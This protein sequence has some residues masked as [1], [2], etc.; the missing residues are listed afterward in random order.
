MTP[1]PFTIAVADDLIADLHRRL[2]ATLWPQA[3][4]GSGWDY[5]SDLGYVQEV[6]EHWRHRYDWRVHERR[7][8]RL[9]QYLVALDG[10][11]VHCVHVPG[12]GPAPLPLVITHGWPSSFAEM[13]D[14]V[15]PLT[16][17]GGHGGDHADAFHVVV[18]SL[19]GY[20]FSSPPT[21]RGMGA[22]RV[23]D[24]WVRLMAAFGYERF[25]SQG[26]DWG[27]AVTTALAVRHPERLVGIHLSMVAPP[28]DPAKLTAEQQIWADALAAYR[29]AE[30]GYVHLQRTKPQ[31]PA[32]ALTDSPA[33]LAAWLVEKWWRWTDCVGP[34]G[35]R[36]LENRISMDQM[37]TVL[38]IYWATRCIGPS[39]RLYAET[40]GPGSTITRPYID[41][42]TGVALFNE[43]NR[44]PRELIEPHFDL[45]RYTRIDDGGHFPAMENPA[46][47]VHEIRE[48]FRPLR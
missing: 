27:S 13:A 16:D 44:P 26:G 20:A 2:D 28:I 23:A 42:P 30:W 41:V 32:F 38:T 12:R 40:F 14:I 29:D 35:V 34:D 3:I 31:T 48:F 5:G 39:M 19:P 6:C 46:A 11:D 24:L 45:R 37:C 36:R 15:G 18:P 43:M 33:G 22:D 4:P 8:N 17:P 1:Q 47:L 7:L 10:L 9:P 21:E 25:A